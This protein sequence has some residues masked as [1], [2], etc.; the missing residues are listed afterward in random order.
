MVSFLSFIQFLLFYLLF[1][2][3]FF[4][5]LL[6]LLLLR[7]RRLRLIDV[8]F[9]NYY[10]KVESDVQEATISEYNNTLNKDTQDDKLISEN[11]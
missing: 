11:R 3:V 5:F 7:R 4:F 9:M 6:P 1:V 10:D 8:A 2:S